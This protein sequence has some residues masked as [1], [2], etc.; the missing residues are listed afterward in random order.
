MR[1]AREAG[2]E[3]RGPGK[4]QREDLGQRNGRAW[5]GAMRLGDGEYGEPEERKNRK[6]LF[7]GHI[8]PV[9]DAGNSIQF[10]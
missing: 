3:Y 9:Q 2:D 1:R 7:N 5:E 10:N 6:L 4:Q 8:V